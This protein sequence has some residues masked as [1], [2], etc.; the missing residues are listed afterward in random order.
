VLALRRLEFERVNR[1]GRGGGGF[2]CCW[3]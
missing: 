1:L 2:G 3:R